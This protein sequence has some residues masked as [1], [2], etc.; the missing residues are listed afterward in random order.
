MITIGIASDGYLS[1]KDKTLAIASN[2]YLDT[3]YTLRRKRGS[4]T[5]SSTPQNTYLTEYL[6]KKEQQM[7][8][9]NEILNILKMF[10][11][12]NYS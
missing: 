11:T 8:E 3:S 9:D 12:C 10:L 2:G 4:G 5:T 6:L 1:K 7:L